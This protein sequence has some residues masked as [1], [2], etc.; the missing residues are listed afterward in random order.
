MGSSSPRLRGGRGSKGGF[1][2]L[3][4]RPEKLAQRLV[5]LLVSAVFRRKGVLLFAPVLYIAGM[6]MY[7][8]TLNL[9]AVQAG[10]GVAILRRAPVGSVYRSPKVFEKL[11]PFMQADGGNSSLA[12][13]SQGSLL[14]HSGQILPVVAAEVLLLDQDICCLMLLISVFFVSRVLDCYSS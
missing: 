5:Y 12:V 2:G 3:S 13:M 8:G 9:D 1:G 7:M 14:G 11:W 10:V 4:T 6:L